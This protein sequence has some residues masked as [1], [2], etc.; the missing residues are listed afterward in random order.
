VLRQRPDSAE[1]EHF[2]GRLYRAKGDGPTAIQHLTR[3]ADL[4]PQIAEYHLYLG[5]AQLESNQLGAASDE[6]SAALEI[7]P[8]LPEAFLVRGLLGNRTGAV[9][10]AKVDFERALALRPTLHEARAGLGDA[11]D[12]LGDRPGAIR[13]YEAAV[14]ADGTQAEWWYRLGRVRFDA[15]RS[16]EA[17]AA[18]GRAIEFGGATE[19]R[20]SWL[21]DA[22]RIRG[23]AHRLG[24]NRAGAIADY[25]RYLEIAPAS[26]LDR[27]DVQERLFDL[28]A[29]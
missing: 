4:D 24:G 10:D 18:L 1:A 2:V 11:L 13:A 6:I 22:Y 28:G 8:Q 16:G 23:E 26:A 27:E 15:G 3:A 5:W 7:D 14:G 21:P 20:P 19:R 25:R 29:R 9:R 17:V 12:Q